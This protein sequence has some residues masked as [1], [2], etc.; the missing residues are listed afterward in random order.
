LLDN[1]EKTDVFGAFIEN[2]DGIIVAFTL[3]SPINDNMID[4]IV[5]KAFHDIIGAYAVI[6][7]DFA[8]NCLQG[9]EFIN[10]EDDMGQENL[11]KA[12]LANFPSEIRTKYLAKLDVV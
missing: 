1:L 7:R 9:F 8:R 6:N 4:I 12:K 2:E 5:E 11:R 10:R 3:A